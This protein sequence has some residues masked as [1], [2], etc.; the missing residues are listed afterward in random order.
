MK[1]ASVLSEHHRDIEACAINGN[2]SRPAPKKWNEH[3]IYTIFFLLS[4]YGDLKKSIPKIIEALGA[5]PHPSLTFFLAHSLTNSLTLGGERNESM[6]RSKMKTLCKKQHKEVDAAIHDKILPEAPY[7]YLPPSSI[8]HL[9]NQAKNSSNNNNNVG[10]KSANVA[11]ST[12]PTSGNS[13]SSNPVSGASAAPINSKM[14]HDNEINIT[15]SSL[16]P[17][18]GEDWVGLIAIATADNPSSSNKD[19]SSHQNHALRGLS[20]SVSP[21]ET[22]YVPYDEKS[23]GNSVMTILNNRCFNAATFSET[24]ATPSNAVSDAMETNQYVNICKNVVKEICMSTISS[25]S[26]LAPHY[27]RGNGHS[28]P[29]LD[30]APPF[31]KQGLLL[32]KKIWHENIF[33][34][35]NSF[36]EHLKEYISCAIQAYQCSTEP[37]QVPVDGTAIGYSTKKRLSPTATVNDKS[38]NSK[39]PRATNKSVVAVLP[40]ASSKHQGVVKSKKQL[41]TREIPSVKNMKKITKPKGKKGF[42]PVVKLEPSTD[43]VGLYNLINSI[44]NVDSKTAFESVVYTAAFDDAFLTESLLGFGELSRDS[45]SRLNN[46]HVLSEI[47]MIPGLNNDYSFAGPSWK[48]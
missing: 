27:G 7:G 9:Y 20:D 34:Q 26:M 38:S 40:A 13:H 35:K 21:R 15:T 28:T 32:Q 25:V 33:N 31:A 24:P 29:R 47:S 22:S 6:I 39:K 30:E 4:V 3:E 11:S 12:L 2:L 23:L 14:T 16:A 1:V 17:R 46:N 45:D 10:N 36:K 19:V 41:N 48:K 8:V 43:S 37:K 44:E 18:K 5:H 42:Q